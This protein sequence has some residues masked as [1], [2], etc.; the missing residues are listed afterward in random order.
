LFFFIQPQ[1]STTKNRFP[2][3]TA[4]AVI[5]LV[6]LLHPLIKAPVM[7]NL[8]DSHSIK[9]TIKVIAVII[10]LFVIVNVFA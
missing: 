6:S 2:S 9:S 1:T 7:F 3:K 8:F 5:V 10:M 4:R